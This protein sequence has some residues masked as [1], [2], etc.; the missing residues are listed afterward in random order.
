MNDV[1]NLLYGFTMEHRQAAYLHSTE[2]ACVCSLYKRLQNELEQSL[3]QEQLDTFAKFCD[4][5]NERFSYEQEAVFCAA[6]S[7]FRE[8]S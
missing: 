5:V 2:Y 1:L 4:T 6:W 8:L 3:T 7:V